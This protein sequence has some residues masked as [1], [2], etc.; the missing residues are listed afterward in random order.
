MKVQR[1]R[2]IPVIPKKAKNLNLQI[3]LTNAKLNKNA[4]VKIKIN[5]YV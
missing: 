3:L 5:Y 1:N 2:V 4:A